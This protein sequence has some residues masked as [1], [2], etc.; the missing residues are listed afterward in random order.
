[1]IIN[2]KKFRMPF[3]YV[4]LF[5]MVVLF[6]FRLAQ[7]QIVEGEYYQRMADSKMLQRITETAPRGGIYTTDGY[8]VAKNR[9]GYSVDLIYANMD[10]EKRNEVFLT[11]FNILDDNDEKFSDDFPIVINGGD[12][13]FTYEN[14]ARKWKEENN[15]PVGSSAQETLDILR[16]R[17]NV[18]EEVNDQIAMQAIEEVHLGQSLPIIMSEGELRFRY[19]SQEEAWKKSYGFK[20]ED[21]DLTAQES[22]GKL[23]ETF[24]IDE[25]YSDSDARKIMLFRQMLKNQGFRS[26]E[27]VEIAKDVKLKTVLEIDSSIHLLPGVSVNARPI[28]EYPYENLASHVIGYIGKVNETDVSENGYNMNDMKGISGIESAFESYLKGEDGLKLTVTDYLGRPQD[29][30]S[31]EAIEP[32]PGSDVYL[33]IDYDLQKVAEEALAQQIKEIRKNNRAPNASSGAVVVMDI[34]TG[35]ILAMASN[36]DYDPNLF[37]TG[38]SSRDWQKLNVIVDDPLYPKPLYNNATLTALQPGSTFKP[39]MAIAGLEKGVITETS[40]IYCRGVHPVFTQFSCL[41]RHGNENVKEAIRDSCNVYFYETG[42]RLGVDNIE[43]YAAAF[44]FGRKT[45]LEIAESAGYLATKEDKKQIWTY[46][47]SDYIRRTVGIEGTEMII[48]TEGDEQLVYKSYAIA[49]ELFQEVD[50]ESY[51]TYGDVYRKASEV[52]GRYNIKETR[53]LHKL[54]EYLLAGRWVASDTIN[55]SIG[56]GGNSFTPIQLASYISTLVNGGNKMEAYLVDK[57]I[58]YDGKTV[59]QHKPNVLEKVDIDQKNVEIVKEGMKMVTMYSTG[60][61]AFAGFDHQ[62]IGVGGKTGTAQY[63]SD[64]VD[65]T[66]WFVAFAPYEEPEIAVVSMIVQGKTSSNSV[67]VARKVIDAYFYDNM[68]Y[69]ERQEE[70]RKQAEEKENQEESDQ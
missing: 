18:K 23:R 48:N 38:I 53:Y 51:K 41:G 43:E 16:D 50:Q 33:T 35:A 26:W 24:K 56:Q 21:L 27:P 61:T 14:E 46:S 32:V 64:S 67:P 15:I 29:G 45:G 13:Y 28:R 4:F 9:I 39:L 68:T 31:E 19:T 8:N 52:L 60:R 3:L 63:G 42:Y 7:L 55:A 12:F 34:K 69:E 5:A 65:N 66:A 10:E 70:E 44:G 30:F 59:Y 25:S 62:N 40:T 11:I 17:Y 20:E 6:L 54:T 57:V 37:S 22:F 58:D 1:M 36:P 47:A 2:D 49:K